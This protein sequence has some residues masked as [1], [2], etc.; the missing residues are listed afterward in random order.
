MKK[1]VN[2]MGKGEIEYLSMD[3]KL[4]VCIVCKS[5]IL[6][7]N[8]MDNFVIA[9]NENE[10]PICFNKFTRVYAIIIQLPSKLSGKGILIPCCR[11]CFYN[12]ISRLSEYLKGE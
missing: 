1:G 12:F 11:K 10:C 5:N 9:S 3:V 6:E 2:K 7:A 4:E 8:K